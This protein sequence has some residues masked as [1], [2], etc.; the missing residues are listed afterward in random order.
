MLSSISRPRVFPTSRYDP[1]D[2]L[3]CVL[4]E[5]THITYTTC[6][7]R[8]PLG[9]RIVRHVALLVTVSYTCSSFHPGLLATRASS[10]EQNRGREEME[11]GYN[12]SDARYFGRK[13]RRFFAET[14]SYRSKLEQFSSHAVAHASTQV[15]SALFPIDEL[16]ESTGPPLFRSH[17]RVSLSLLLSRSH[18]R[19]VH[20]P[21]YSASSFSLACTHARESKKKE[22]SQT[23]TDAKMFSLCTVT[24]RTSRHIERES[25]IPCSFLRLQQRAEIL[26]Q[27]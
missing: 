14:D 21:C 4:H 12:Y 20:A 15:R 1:L 23:R 22:R 19:R 10:R 5:C 3:S 25:R 16:I 27:L 26:L 13:E 6:I 9:R 18:S 24:S 8:T 7:Q 11:V 2:L 17:S